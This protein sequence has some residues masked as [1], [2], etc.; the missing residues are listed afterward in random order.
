MYQ[1]LHSADL[2]KPVGDNKCLVV[3]LPYGSGLINQLIRAVAVSPDKTAG[4]EFGAAKI[5]GNG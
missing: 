3:Y 2:I 4:T 1:M 5:T